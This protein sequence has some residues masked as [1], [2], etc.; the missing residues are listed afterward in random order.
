[1]LVGTLAPPYPPRVAS[2]VVGL[3]SVVRAGWG[4]RAP[5]SPE[6]EKGAQGAPER[7]SAGAVVPR[8]LAACLACGPVLGAGAWSRLFRGSGAVVGGGGGGRVGGGRG[9]GAGPRPPVAPSARFRGQ[10][11][12][13]PR[14]AVAPG[15]RGPLG[16]GGGSGARAV[17][18][19]PVLR[20]G[21][22][23]RAI[24]SS[25]LS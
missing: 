24:K 14:A 9:C 5:T 17:V 18:G 16:P 11:R 2:G 8:R 3:P 20:F 13:A 19:G 4:R 25:L 21:R 12:L 10:N 6:F 7:P 23:F 15:G 1:M 22:P